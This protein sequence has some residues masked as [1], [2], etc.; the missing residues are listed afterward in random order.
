MT[1][2]VGMIG[3][4]EGNGHPFSFSA[5]I[6][7]FSDEGMAAS[8]WPGIHNYLRRRDA[9]EFGGLGLKVTHV[10]SQ[11]EE[12]TEKLRLACDI[13]CVVGGSD[14]GAMV[15]KVDAVIIARD[16]HANHLEMALPFL[17]AGASVFIDKP[18]T[19]NLNE[20]RSFEPYLRAGR[21][22]SCSGMRFAREL[23][24]ARSTIEDYGELRLIQGAILN[25]WPRYG[26]HLVDAV[27]NLTDSRPTAVTALPAMHESL[28]VQMDDGSLFQVDALGNVAPCFDLAIYG[29]KRSS[30]H[31]IR[32]NF[33]MFRRLMFHFAR[34]VHTGEPGIPVED[35]LTSI[36]LLIAG[37]LALQEKRTVRLDEL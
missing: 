11:D 3:F 14:P 9:S 4:S 24:E 30:S 27:L 33:S 22:M 7:G 15:G 19:L 32:D 20:L 13:D 12:A 10:W 26:V 17:E 2:S 16:D 1:V 28:A 23:D 21:L 18:L 36:K 37:Q 25:D 5:I 31:E 6:N 8:G 29:T 35:M 34:S